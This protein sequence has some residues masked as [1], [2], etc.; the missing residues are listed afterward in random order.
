MVDLRAERERRGMTV[1]EAATRAQIPLRFVAAL[2]D[3]DNN[4]TPPGPFIHS[5][6]RQYLE[7]LGVHEALPIADFETNAEYTVTTP[8]IPISEVP[9][10]RLLI[11]A[12]VLTTLVVLGLRVIHAVNENP[13]TATAASEFPVAATPTAKLR[14]RAIETTWIVTRID[15]HDSY[16]GFLAAEDHIDLQGNE[17]IEL[18]AS[19]LTNISIHYNGDRIEPLGNLTLGRRLVFIQD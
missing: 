9:L 7:F 16:R 5:Y 2:E 8:T 13:N 1:E 18:Y 12:F 10:T 3:P 14:I 19:D 15:E 17:I 4:P 6:R 11:A